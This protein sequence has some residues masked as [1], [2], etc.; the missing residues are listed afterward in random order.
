MNGEFNVCMI[1]AALAGSLLLLGFLAFFYNI[2]TSLRLK[3][4]IGIFTPSKLDTTDPVP[5]A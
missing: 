3:G 5:A 2:V 1:L 4:V